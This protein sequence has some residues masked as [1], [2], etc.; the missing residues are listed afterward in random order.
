MITGLQSYLTWQK[1]SFV[2][3]KQD[4]PSAGYKQIK[5]AWDDSQLQSSHGKDARHGL[6]P[7][8]QNLSILIQDGCGQMYFGNGLWCDDDPGNLGGWLLKME[9]KA[10]MASLSRLGSIDGQRQGK[11]QFF[12]HCNPRLW[13]WE[14]SLATHQ[15]EILPLCL[16]CCGH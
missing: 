5:Q 15:R 4:R 10:K 12:H 2:V 14:I 1:N 11:D 6:C 16:G 7:Y 3:K 9:A 13:N 8:S